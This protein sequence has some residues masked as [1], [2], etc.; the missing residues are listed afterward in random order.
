MES[1][2]LNHVTLSSDSYSIKIKEN[3]LS[4]ILRVTFKPIQ[5]FQVSTQELYKGDFKKLVELKG[6][7]EKFKLYFST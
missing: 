4:G 6:K 3:K 7:N 5:Q 1:I 2:F